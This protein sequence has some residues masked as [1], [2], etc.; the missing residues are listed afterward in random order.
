[1]VVNL[2]DRL[3]NYYTLIRTHCRKC[4]CSGEIGTYERQS[5][6][7]LIDLAGSERAQTAGTKG[8][9]LTEVLINALLDIINT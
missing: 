5:K 4:R 1:V 3:C 7:N 8:K 6:I 2:T 9:Q